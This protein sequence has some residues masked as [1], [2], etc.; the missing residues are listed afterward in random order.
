MP[1]S[2]PASHSELRVMSPKQRSAGTSRARL[3]RDAGEAR[4]LEPTPAFVNWVAVQDVEVRKYG[5]AAHD[6]E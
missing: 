1:A 5:P 4:F 2:G 6:F 3:D